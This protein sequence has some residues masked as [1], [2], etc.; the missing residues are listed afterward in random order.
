M[1]YV[2]QFLLILLLAILASAKV[3]VQGYMSRKQI[4]T[5]Q[6]S[7]WFNSMVFA[8]IAVFLAILFPMG[9]INGTLIF[10]SIMMTI[11]N[12]AFQCCYAIALRSGPVSLTV[13]IGNFNILITTSFSC[14]F[15]GDSLYMTQVVAIV[16]LILSMF[17]ASESKPDEK[18]ATSKWL[19]LSLVCM[20]CSATYGISQ[21]L[22]LAT[23]E[24]LLP[25]AQAT[26]LMLSYALS[27]VFG[28]L[29]YALCIPKGGRSPLG[30]QKSVVGYALAVGLLL[31]IYQRLNIYTMSVVEGT[32][33]FPTY[34]GMQ[35]LTM[36]LVGII[37]FKDRLSRKQ[38]WGVACGIISVVL[39]NMRLGIPI[40]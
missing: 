5:T 18:K 3:T 26:E 31:C 7:V 11:T 29:I 8:V 23:P 13:L 38:M 19:I 37:L 14:L 15:M 9:E 30:F 34:A 16:L 21:K 32:F 39:M 4:H 36:T 33:H 17:L 6:D 27:A 24:A 10:Y 1:S 12:I 35:S 2:Y 28:F 20:S 22:F 25:N 40:A